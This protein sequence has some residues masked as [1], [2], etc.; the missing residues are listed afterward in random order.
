MLAREGNGNSSTPIEMNKIVGEGY[1][2]G[3]N[4][5]Q[6]GTQFITG[7]KNGKPY[8]AFSLIR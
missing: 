5:Y 7:F 6:T 1:L 3:G 8:T 4:V 2:S